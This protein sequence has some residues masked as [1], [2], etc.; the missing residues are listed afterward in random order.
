[1]VHT[2]VVRSFELPPLPHD[3]ST[4]P[5][6]GGGQGDPTILRSDDERGQIDAPLRRKGRK[7]HAQQ[8]G[9]PLKN[10]QYGIVIDCGSSGSRLFAYAWKRRHGFQDVTADHVYERSGESYVVKKVEPGISSLT[11]EEAVDQLDELLSYA[12]RHIP[13]EAHRD[14]ILYILATAG[15]RMIPIDQRTKLLRTIGKE[16]RRK[17]VFRLEEV[18]V[19]SGQDEG[20]FAW[21]SINSIM[22]RLC[23]QESNPVAI[24]DMGGGSIQVAI[25]LLDNEKET[26]KNLHIS[27]ADIQ[28]IDLSCG[29]RHKIFIHTWLG[30][31][32][33]KA[34]DRYDQFI[35]KNSSYDPCL[36]QG[37]KQN[38]HLGTSGSFQEC[39]RAISGAD[40]FKD[41][42]QS[43]SVLSALSPAQAQLAGAG[44]VPIGHDHA[45][46]LSCLDENSDIAC[47]YPLRAS[48]Q[49][50]KIDLEKLELVGISEFYYTNEDVFRMSGQFDT[51]AFHKA[52]IEW[53][54]LTKDEIYTNWR[55]E[56]YNAQES[57]LNSQCF[58]AAWLSVMLYEGLGFD[59]FSSQFSLRTLDN[60]EGK[61]LQ[62]TLGA[63]LYKSGLAGFDRPHPRA[64]GG[65]PIQDYEEHP[66]SMQFERGGAIGDYNP[67]SFSENTFYALLFSV[68]SLVILMVIYIHRSGGVDRAGS[69]FLLGDQ[70]RRI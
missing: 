30:Y 40:V 39:R 37:L 3:T 70:V 7:E 24:M 26:Q 36:P 4:S 57:R 52:A 5:V 20:L 8:Q 12:S 31:G 28:T 68:M 66:P 19:I 67:F 61:S 56:R 45:S 63:L 48:E 17:F 51:N 27:T 49:L 1:M 14:T 50:P 47:T 64:P 54:S 9:E 46:L 69:Y 15:L 23:N 33:N 38:S 2:N 53:C 41:R 11:P 10:L 65:R 60:I 55:A 35:L 21:L 62:W 43:D 25:P 16:I 58:K 6:E 42:E 13:E 22:G 44:I 32:A 59:I 34:R 18:S 29:A